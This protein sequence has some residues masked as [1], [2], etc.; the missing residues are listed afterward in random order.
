MP[1]SSSSYTRQ[2]GCQARII[3]ECLE[4]MIQLKSSRPVQ[5]K[6]RLLAAVICCV[7]LSFLSISPCGAE[8]VDCVVAKLNDQIIMR[9]D[10][11]DYAAL[12]SSKAALTSGVVGLYLDRTLLVQAV[13]QQTKPAEH[14]VQE[15]VE[16][17]IGEMRRQY[18]SER[19]FLKDLEEGGMTLSRLKEDL[20]KRTREDVQAYRA[21]AS[22][23][24]IGD[25][26]VERYEQECRK[27]GKAAVAIHLRRLGVPV[28]SGGAAAARERVRELLVKINTEGKPFEQGVRKYSELPGAQQDGG[29]LGYLDL[30]TLAPEVRQAV[31]SLEPGQ[32][33]VPMITGDCASIFYVEGKRSSKAILV[34]KRFREERDKYIDELR[35]KAHLVVYDQEFGKKLPPEYRALAQDGRSVALPAGATPVVMPQSTPEKKGML[36]KLFSKKQ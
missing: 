13:K 17:T 23:F 18:A 11:T 28:G 8:V 16:R 27:H 6:C 30:S 1:A 33:S 15:E 12:G 20:M 31:A 21:V 26:D 14:E 35:K 9:S 32:A 3:F 19:E 36:G 10:L 2:K 24:S 5:R 34:E 4:K 7:V 22:R 29:E 25:G